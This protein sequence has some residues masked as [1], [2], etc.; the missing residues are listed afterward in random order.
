MKQIWL[1][2]V[3]PMALPFAVIY[4][5]PLLGPEI[6]YREWILLYPLVFAIAW[7]SGRRAGIIATA[8]SAIAV[9]VLLRHHHSLSWLNIGIFSFMG[10]A[11]SWVTSGNRRERELQKAQYFLDSLLENIPNMV[12]VKDARD[13]RFV[14]F[15]KAGEELLGFDRKDLI[16]KNDYDFFPKEQAD[17]FVSKDRAVLTGKEVVDIPEE[18][19]LSR[20]LGERILHTKKIPLYDENGV[21]TYLLG[22]SEDIT[23]KKQ[24]ER[25]VIRMIAEEAR[26]A[27]RERNTR[28]STYLGEASTVLAR[29]LDYRESLNE[30]MRIAVPEM[31]DW[32]TVAVLGE[33]GKLE[34]LA[35][36]HADPALAET[37]NEFV[38]NYSF[39]DAVAGMPELLEGRSVLRPVITDE[40][41]AQLARDQRQLALL[42]KLGAISA[43]LVPIVSRGKVLGVMSFN[44]GS[45]L[46]DE[47]DLDLAQELARRAGTAIDNALLYTSA[48]TAIRARDEFI[49]I[50]SHELKTPI[51]ALKLQFQMALRTPDFEKSQRALTQ[52]LFHVDR[53]SSLVEGLLDVSRIQTRRLTLTPEECDLAELLS[54]VVESHRSQLTEKG[55]ALTTVFEPGIR[56]QWDKLR[57]GQVLSN[58]ITNVLKYAP[59]APV[60]IEAHRHGNRVRISVHDH[61]PG[62][63]EAQ[64]HSIFNRFERGTH[65]REVSG[66]GLGLY[67]VRQIVQAHGGTIFLDDDNSVGTKMIIDLP[68]HPNPHPS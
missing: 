21:A 56:G 65:S 52:G 19:L 24:H 16:G 3:L 11:I 4:F 42:R 57:L 59:G 63:P 46:Y 60:S 26:I 41:L 58:L 7:V 45:K 43:M 20:T 32:S 2:F 36:A 40:E 64:K 68:L 15:N 54:E 31:G 25:E 27:E 55:C 17:F 5:Q 50:A 35:Q 39:I 67:I 37:L 66:L 6:A 14:R 29:T 51:T 12:F 34:R 49:S 38:G 13:L 47:E 28:R 22:V 30:L 33:D 9:I 62:I 10:T 48:Q 61:G 23:E 53:L 44:S 18:S 8:C 1:Q